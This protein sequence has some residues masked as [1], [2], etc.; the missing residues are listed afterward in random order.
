MSR[1]YRIRVSEKLS[2]IVHVEDGVQTK[3]E[4]LNILPSGEM[5]ELLAAELEKEGFEREGELLVRVDEEGIRV[6]V[7]LGDNTVTVEAS[8]ERELNIQ[9]ERSGVVWEEL[10]E[11][12]RE[13]MS[14]EA[15]DSLEDRAEQEERAL[16]QLVNQ[17]LERRLQGTKGELDRA[18][19][20]TTIEAL[21]RRAA[22]LGEIQEINEDTESGSLT[23]R[24]KV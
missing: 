21:K 22:Q 7:D 17:K 13:A 23:I 6:I 10:M 2:R 11:Q 14:K 12:A 4:L 20:Q 1:A 18:V 8:E 5:A 3:L 19:N 15:N 16:R 24:V 9:E